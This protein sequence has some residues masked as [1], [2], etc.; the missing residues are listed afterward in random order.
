MKHTTKKTLKKYQPGGPNNDLPINK[1]VAKSK[2][3][4]F[5]RTIQ[6]IKT[7]QK[8]LRIMLSS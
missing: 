3:D 8:I 7:A 5:G 1:G 2:R 6:T 4:I